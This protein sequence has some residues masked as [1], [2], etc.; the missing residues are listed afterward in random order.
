V[1][2]IL[3][4]ESDGVL[5]HHVSSVALPMKYSPLF[6]C[7]AVSCKMATKYEIGIIVYS[8]ESG[9]NPSRNTKQL[10]GRI[11]KCAGRNPNSDIWCEIVVLMQ[12]SHVLSAKLPSLCANSGPESFKVKFRIVK[13]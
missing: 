12:C 5:V 1:V 2:H 7:Y 11:M 8:Q 13:E 4:S 9:A 6:T 10:A 3:S